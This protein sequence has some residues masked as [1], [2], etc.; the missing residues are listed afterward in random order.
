[1]IDP[2]ETR[3]YR[4]KNGCSLQEAKRAIASER[5]DAILNRIESGIRPGFPCDAREIVEIVR[6]LRIERGA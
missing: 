2:A 1:M 3:A 6:L 4:D 5:L